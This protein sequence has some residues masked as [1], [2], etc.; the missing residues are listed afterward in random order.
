MGFGEEGRERE[1]RLLNVETLPGVVEEGR[2]RGEGVGGGGERSSEVGG[3]PSGVV[4]E[5]KEER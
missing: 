4:E 2:V 5:G 3:G 1:E